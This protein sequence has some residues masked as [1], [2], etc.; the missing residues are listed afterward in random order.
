MCIRYIYSCT[1]FVQTWRTFPRERILLDI[2]REVFNRRTIVHL[3][4]KI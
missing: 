1:L 3:F 2:L 4:F